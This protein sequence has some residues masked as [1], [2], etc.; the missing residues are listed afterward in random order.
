MVIDRKFIILAI[1][2]CN[3]E[4]H[5]QEDAIL[6]CAHDKAVPNML[7]TYYAECEKLNCDRHHLESIRLL[8]TRVE[9]YQMETKSKVPDTDTTCEIDRC[10]HGKGIGLV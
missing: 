2:P 7:R 3:G 5:T 4:L 1:N 9:V 10:I 8:L 6:F